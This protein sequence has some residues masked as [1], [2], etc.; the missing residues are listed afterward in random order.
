MKGESAFDLDRGQAE[1]A[2]ADVLGDEAFAINSYSPDI[3]HN[4]LPAVPGVPISADKPEETAPDVTAV[5][6]P[7]AAPPAIVP[8]TAPAAIPDTVPPVTAEPT[9]APAMPEAVVRVA[10]AV[11]APAVAPLK[12]APPLPTAPPNSFKKSGMTAGNG[13]TSEE[14]EQR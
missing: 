5:T 8:P 7:D 11:V 14:V 13:P 1:Q 10:A 3:R 12:I 2:T 9:T 6:A 4:R